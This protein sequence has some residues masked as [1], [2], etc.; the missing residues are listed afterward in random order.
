MGA[1]RQLLSASQQT[2]TEALQR[3]IEGVQ[4]EATMAANGGCVRPFAGVDSLSAG[5]HRAFA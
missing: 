2:L 4:G 5:F 1:S 3:M